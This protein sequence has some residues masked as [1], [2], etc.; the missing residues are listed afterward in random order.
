MEPVPYEFKTVEELKDLIDYEELVMFDTETVGLYGKIRLAQFHQKSW[1]HKAIMVE[2]PDPFALVSALTKA[3]CVMH[4]AHY[5]ITTIQENL[6][7]ITWMPEQYECTFLLGRLHYYTQDSFSLDN[8]VMYVLGVDIYGDDKK[9]MHKAD[10]SVPILSD[11]QLAY[12]A[13]DVVY[14]QHVYDEVKAQKDNINYKLDIL[15]SRYAL[16]FQNNGL[17]FDEEKLNS[18]YSKN[19]RRIEEIALPINCNSW[20]QVRPYIGSQMSDDL[21][22]STLI[23]QGNERAAAVKETRKLTKEN[24]FLTKFLNTE[25]EGCIFGKFKFSPRSGRSSS[26]DQNLQQLPRSTKG[27]FGVSTECDDVLI[28]SDFSQMQLRAVCA[29]TG[30]VTMQELFRQGEDLHDYV[31][32]IIFGEDFT[33]TQRQIC[34]TA[35]FGLL[36]GAGVATFQNILL[37][38]AGLSLSEDEAMRIKKKWL[39]LWKQVAAWQ[40]SGIRAWKKKDAWETPLGRRYTA[41]MMTDQL[42]MQIQGFE[43]EVAKLAMHY[44]LPRLTE[45]DKRIK[46]RNFVHDSYIFTCPKERILYEQASLIIAE[47]MQEG[48]TEMSQSVMIK[49]LPMPVNVRV[50]YNWGDIEN[51]EFI[52]EFNKD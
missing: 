37:K 17:P 29:V 2:Y 10:W 4:N 21:G 19:Q 45:L 18:Q 40:T 9:E 50:G 25:R 5:D 15:A 23:A 41:K 42:A 39:S 44:M 31:A 52:Y 36:F 38:Q 12:A 34:K 16:D 51:G 7:H 24:S 3:H 49:D 14:L 28:Y 35:N 6:G 27:I 47:S 20:Q 46:L 30:D 8:I 43:A 26:D 1:G 22:L 11:K 33:K 13:S 48:W 32:K